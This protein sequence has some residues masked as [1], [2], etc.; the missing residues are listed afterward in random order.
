MFLSNI[1]EKTYAERVRTGYKRNDIIDACIDAMNKSEEIEEFKNDKEA[2]LV[3]NAAMLFFAGFDTQGYYDKIIPI[4]KQLVT[5]YFTTGITI[6]MIF[7]YLMKFPDYQEKVAEEI[8]AALESHDDVVS[9]ELI[10]NLKY[11]EM[12]MKESMR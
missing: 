11:T 8:A 6:S 4:Y 7:H 12:F 10:E 5:V 3:A 9:Y 2:I 1:I